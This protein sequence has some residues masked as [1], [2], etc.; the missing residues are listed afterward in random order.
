MSRRTLEGQVG[1]LE[2]LVG[3]LAGRNDGSIADQRIVD[4]RIR[5]QVGL[6]LVQIN[7]KRTVKAQRRGDGAD[8]LGDQA[9]EVLVARA[10]DI[11][12]ATA[13]VVD[14]FVVDKE[15]AVGVLDRAVGRQNG[16]VRLDD[17]SGHA[18]CRV[19]SKLELA[20]LAVLGG[21]ALEEQGTE[22]RASTTTKGMEDQE[23]LQA[24]AVVCYAVVSHRASATWHGSC[25]VGPADYSPATR[26]MRSMTLSTISLPMV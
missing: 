26:R 4:T 25:L 16:V 19:N 10:S 15:S 17:S 20:L 22:T 5:D 21:Q 2:A 7:V 23:T 24:A 6:E 3:A 1:S 9:V 13:D 12:V 14:G 18:R 11:K 8:D